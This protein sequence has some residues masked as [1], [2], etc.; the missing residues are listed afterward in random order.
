M[1]AL[2]RFTFDLDMADRPAHAMSSKPDLP[3][4]PVGIPEDVVARLVQEAREEGYAA[5]LVAGESNATSLATQTIAAAAGTLAAHAAGMSAN[6]DLARIDNQREAI[7]LALSVGRKLAGHLISSRPTAEL[8]ALIAECMPSL[9]GVPHLVIRCN[10]E[11][12]DQIR[13][14]ATAQIA[15][16]GYAG[17][18]VVMGEPDIRLGD[19][20]L[21]WVDGGLVRDSETLDAE[22]DRTISDYLAALSGNAGAHETKESGE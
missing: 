18:L 15:T 17:R 9:A 19:G 22:I 1:A 8:E 11:L 6:L 14:I 12:A 10:S 21:E 5:G 20:R 2:A 4:Q 3:P 16:S 7:G 13:D